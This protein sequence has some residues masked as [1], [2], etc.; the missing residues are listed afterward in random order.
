[1]GGVREGE[2]C[3]DVQCV[4]GAYQLGLESRVPGDLLMQGWTA[5][6]VDLLCR[7]RSWGYLRCDFWGKTRSLASFLDVDREGWVYLLVCSG[8]VG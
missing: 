2:E 6:P 3:H 7:S 8:R 4:A 1:M 5:M